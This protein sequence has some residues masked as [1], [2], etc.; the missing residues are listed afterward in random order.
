MK[1]AWSIA[2]RIALLEDGKIS[3]IGTFEELKRKSQNLLIKSF[4][5]MEGR[6]EKKNR[7]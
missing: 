5:E 7:N 4:V 2:E 6:D 3:E 1:L